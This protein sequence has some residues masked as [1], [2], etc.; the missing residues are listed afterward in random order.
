ML[1]ANPTDWTDKG[2]VI[3]DSKL[4]TEKTS[5]WQ[6][7]SCI[8]RNRMCLVSDKYLRCGNRDVHSQHS[9]HRCDG[10]DVRFS[11]SIKSIASNNSCTFL[12]SWRSNSWQK[13]IISWNMSTCISALHGFNSQQKITATFTITK[14]QLFLSKMKWNFYTETSPQ[15]EGYT[16]INNNLFHCKLL[17]WFW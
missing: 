1:N 11:Y 3:L 4:A 2:R 7:K 17:N 6:N 8:Q 15:P 14:K 12:D 13:Q 5:L 9:R 10:P 16:N